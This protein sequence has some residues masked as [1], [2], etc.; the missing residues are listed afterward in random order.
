MTEEPKMSPEEREKWHQIYQI[1]RDSFLEQ[2]NRIDSLD[3]KAQINLIV[4]GIVLGFGLFKTEFIS[5]LVAQITV[6]NFILFSQFLCLAS[7]FALFVVSF[8]FSIFGLKPR[9]FR[10]YP[11]VSE[12]MTKFDEKKTE[13]LH[14]SMSAFFQKVIKDNEKALQSKTN[15]LKKS[16][17]LILIAFLLSAASIVLAVIPKLF[18]C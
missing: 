18:I 15:C 12:L 16:L 14:A 17:W 8:T 3:R 5:T 1:A 13:D 6:R 10:A 4:I 9:F 7:S 11:E 2:L